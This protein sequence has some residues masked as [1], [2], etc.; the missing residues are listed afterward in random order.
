MPSVKWFSFV[1]ESRE[2]ERFYRERWSYDKVVRSSHGV[3]CSMSCSWMVYVKDGLVVWELQATDYPLIS[4]DIPPHEP[5][6]CQ[7]GI[8]SSWYLY[9]PLR[10]KYPYVRRALWEMYAEARRRGLDP[11]EA[12]AS[13]V[14]DP[15]K[16]RRYKR[17]RGKGGWKRVSWDEAL[18][19]I[20]GAVVYTIKKYGPDR[21][22]FFSPIPAMSMVSFAS[23]MRLAGLLGAVI[24]SFYDW[25]NDLPLAS[26]QVWG[27]Q[28]DTHESADW[29]NSTY[30]IVSGTSLPTTRTADAHFYVEA[31]YNGAKVV[32][33]SPDYYDHVKFADVWVPIKPGSDAAL[34]L[35]MA[36]VI[37]KE[38]YVDRTVDYFV[39]Y[40]K[41]YT[42]LPFL[43]VLERRGDYYVPGRFLRGSQLPE[44]Q[45]E[46]LA[47][48]KLLVMDSR[49]LK[50][51]MPLG[52][53]GFRWE[54]REG[55]WNLKMEDAVTGEKI[56]PLLTLLGVEDERVPVAFPYFGDV[57]SVDP[58]GWGK[59]GKPSLVVREVPAKRVRTVDGREVLVTTVFDLLMAHLGVKRP[60]LGGDY[61][62]GYDDPKP[63]TPAWQERFTGVSRDLVIKIAREFAENAARTRGRS[64]LILGPGV[65]HWYH[66]ALAYRA[67]ILLVLLTGSVGRHGGGWSHYVGTE[68]LRTLAPVVSI[69]F[70]LDWTGPPRLQASTLFWY[71][72]SGQWKY[73]GLTLDTQWAPT[74]G[75][76]VRRY[77]HTA[78]FFAMA[79]RTGWMPFYP[80]FNE[81]PIKLAEEAEKAGAR[82]PEEIVKYVVDKLKRGE[83]RFAIEDPDAPQNSPKV[84]FVWRGNLVGSSFRGVEHFLKTM[85][86]THNSVLGEERAKGLVRELVWRETPEGKLD[87]FVALEFRMCSTANYADVVLP[88]AHWYEKHD[89]TCGDLH[90]FIHPFNPATDPYWEARHEWEIFKDLARKIS[91]LAKKH[92]PKP[93]K[94]I[95]VHPFLH[96]TPQELAQPEGDI[97]DW[98]Y[99]DAEP[100]P[101][102]TMPNMVV[103]ERDYTKVYDMFVKLGPRIRNRFGAKGIFFPLGELYDRLKKDPLIG[104]KDG[105][106]SLETPVAVAE[107]ILKLAPETN[108]EVSYRAWKTLERRT[109]VN[110]SDIAERVRHVEYTFNDITAQPRRVIASPMWTGIEE[111][112]R[113]YC[114][115]TLNVERLVPWRTL[116]G[117]QHVYIDHAV[118]RDYGEALPTYKPPVDHVA[119]GDVPAKLPP[120]AKLFRYSTPHPKWGIHSSFQDNLRM[121]QLFRGGPHVYMNP[122]DAR[123]LGVKDND[124]VEIWSAH[125]VTVCRV[126]TSPRVPRG[127]IIDYHGRERHVNMPVSALAVEAGKGPV[128]GGTNNS[129][130]RILPQV[131]AAVGGY[132]QLSYFLNYYGPTPSE[133]DIIVAVRK[134]PLGPEGKPVYP[135]PGQPVRIT[136]RRG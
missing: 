52:S 100:V 37:L 127:F 43:V 129:P 110:L 130:T 23:G 116:S 82:T 17:A 132:A 8:S 135:R 79:V 103:V 56:D 101:G 54:R 33:I 112:G 65:M 124:W 118:F 75:E 97:L 58:E 69:A 83:L 86:G 107:A 120:G 38:F 85:L 7:R 104:E 44:Y 73:D 36:H 87:L 35:A 105:Y 70:A 115:Y 123:E 31:R 26:P 77:R 4:P 111:P 131:T 20:A 102:R 90:T 50:P 15:E 55:R 72:H 113:P 13:I 98:K 76:K 109:G 122:E 48:W 32:V 128:V 63:Y 53:I 119:I 18:E 40:V 62:E 117:R 29:Y 45:G 46:E 11:V 94:D 47:E 81:N 92:L 27:E 39:D 57:F 108:G 14:E 91:E 19:L 51:M 1:R 22:A 9:S 126:V 125:G 84:L 21:I 60:G 71:I 136:Y 121:L 66:Q 88:V 78:D 89:L 59:V 25:Y 114:P 5:R 2:W 42:D 134:L 6:G 64:L 133:R 68:K 49:K 61:P 3:N 16:A 34:A 28:T 30:I 10:V 99:G 80:S 12:W 41:K 96:D 74:A 95:V 106:P 24:L 67:Y 93:V